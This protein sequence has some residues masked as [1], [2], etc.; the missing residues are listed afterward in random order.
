MSYFIGGK[1]LC[2]QI[3]ALCLP[4]GLTLVITPLIALMRD[5][6]DSLRAKG[7]AAAH[8]DSTLTAEQS[9][10]VKDG[11]MNGTIQL[12]YVA[13][14]RLNNEGFLHMA[15]QVNINLLAI[16]E[17]HCISEWGSNFRPDYLKIARFSQELDVERVLCLTATATAQVAQDICT[18][19]NI[20]PVAGLFKTA[21]FRSKYVL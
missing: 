11:V 5:Q 18:A 12:L 2:F 4:Q 21:V 7:V 20:D 6:V 8:L 13:P 15:S 3:P 9:R 19:F 10:L 1:S 17:S 14:E 16:D